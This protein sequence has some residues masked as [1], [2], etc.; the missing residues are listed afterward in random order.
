MELDFVKLHGL[1]NDFVFMDDFSR[2]INLTK[3]QVAL[4]CDRHFGIGAD[5]VILV[6]PSERSECAAYMHYI[7][8]DGTLAQMCG[9]GVRCFAKYL[10]DRGYVQASD[11]Q[12]VADTLAGPKP[13]SFEVDDRDK[14]TR[15]TVDMG[16]PILEPSDVPVNVPANAT[17]ADGAAFAKD[18]A[19]T[20]PWGT[21]AFTCV[22][23][24][25]PHAICF[26]DDFAQ[27]SDELFTN[28]NDKSLATLD[29]NKIGAYYE[30]HEA[31]P[32]KTNV[33][34]A[35]VRSG[36][37]DMRVFERGCG[38]TLACGTGACATNVA[39]ALTGRSGRE[40]DIVLRG[41]TLHILWDENDHVMMTGPAVE[42]FQGTV[43]V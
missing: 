17:S 8:S 31:F 35:Y 4:L 18:V 19:I 1:G 7:N 11:G 32:E 41:G 39:A 23:M 14:M 29:L 6:R 28:A 22:S 12:F 21:F 37:I 13:I 33:E 30:S 16:H 15:A 5:G 25:N 34:F 43:E 3:E 9:N 24:G 2:D 20:S 26:I 42:S 27:L 10:V 40:N 38:E 36:A